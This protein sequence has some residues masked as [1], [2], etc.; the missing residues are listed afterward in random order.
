MSENATDSQQNS[1]LYVLMVMADTPTRTTLDQTFQ[2]G[3]FESHLADSGLYALTMLERNPIDVVVIAKEASDMSGWDFYEIVIS[4]TNLR[5]VV[6]VLLDDNARG[7]LDGSSSAIALPEATPGEQIYKAAVS[8]LRQLGRIGR[9]T[10]TSASSVET[11][12]GSLDSFFS[13]VDLILSLTGK[14]VTGELR[15][16]FASDANIFFYKGQLLHATVGSQAGE[17]ALIEIFYQVDT[18]GNTEYRFDNLELDR[19]P[20]DKRT[21]DISVE[22]LLFQVTVELDYRR[23]GNV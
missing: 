18:Q 21:I 12:Q 22:K 5:R 9:K 7:K 13:L 16:S 19:A 4:D 11:I 15:F 23:K 3:G 1:D 10:S 2:K 8:K 6:V 14:G 20:E 17:D